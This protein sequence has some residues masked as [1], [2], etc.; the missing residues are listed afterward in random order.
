M[1]Q[2]PDTGIFEFTGGTYIRQVSGNVAAVV[3]S[4]P[5]T[6]GEVGSV[7]SPGET[8]VDGK[9]AAPGVLDKV[10]NSADLS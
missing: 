9:P 7:S 6:S 8:S 3:E 4:S 5:V 1:K 2:N 10:T